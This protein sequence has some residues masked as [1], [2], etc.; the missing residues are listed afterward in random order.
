MPHQAV[1]CVPQCPSDSGGLDPAADSRP[2]SLVLYVS[3]HRTEL[4][5]GSQ[6]GVCHFRQRTGTA[7]GKPLSGVE[8]GVIHGFGRLQIDQEH[9]RSAALGDREQH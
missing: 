2:G 3:G 5:T 4:D 9:G 7:V 8:V 6:K 1:P